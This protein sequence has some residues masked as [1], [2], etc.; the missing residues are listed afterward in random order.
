[1][2]AIDALMSEAPAGITKDLA[3][4]VFEAID[5]EKKHTWDQK[6]C[7]FYGNII[8]G[9][10]NADSK[11]LRTSVMGAVLSFEEVNTALPTLLSL[12]KRERE[13]GH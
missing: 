2:R 12:M 4:A 13:N 10:V 8:E 3:F 9:K 1:M 11:S 5:S 6:R 7:S